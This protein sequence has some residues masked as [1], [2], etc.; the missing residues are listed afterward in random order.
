[1]GWHDPILIAMHD[2]EGYVQLAD[3]VTV[4]EITAKTEARFNVS[5][6]QKAA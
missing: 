6:A 5:L 1:M 4:E 2:E 3:G